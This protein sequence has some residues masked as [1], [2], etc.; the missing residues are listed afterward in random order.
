MSYHQLK[1]KPD[2]N[3]TVAWTTSDQGA[4][5]ASES[6]TEASSDAAAADQDAAQAEGASTTH[7]DVQSGDKVWYKTDKDG[8][9]IPIAVGEDKPK[10]AQGYVVARDYAY[11]DKL[12]VM[13]PGTY[14]AY[15]L[16]DEGAGFAPTSLA[17]ETVVV[18]PAS[19]PD[20]GDSSSEEGSDTGTDIVTRTVTSPSTT[21]RTTS[22]TT[23][24]AKT[25]DATPTSMAAL[26]LLGAAVL[27]FGLNRR[28]S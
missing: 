26:G 4:S 1:G 22:S 27:A 7:L 2:G 14:Q 25:A 3:P 13:E 23:P 9:K 12:G 11:A 24:L 6:G 28:R 8:W 5:Q 15:A 19:S 20:Q 16:F 17:E 10:E 18:N 21:T